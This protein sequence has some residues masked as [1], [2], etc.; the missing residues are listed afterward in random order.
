MVGDAVRSSLGGSRSD[1][2]VA[3]PLSLIGAVGKRWSSRGVFDASTARGP[4]RVGP[5]GLLRILRVGVATR[6]QREAPTEAQTKRSRGLAVAA[7]RGERNAAT[8]PGGEEIGSVIGQTGIDVERPVF[9]GRQVVR[10]GSTRPL[11]LEGAT[12]KSEPRQPPYCVRRPHAA[13]RHLTRRDALAKRTSY[14]GPQQPP[15]TDRSRP[16]GQPID[17]SSA[18]LPSLFPSS[19]IGMRVSS[20]RRT[21]Q[22]REPIVP[23][24]TRVRG[25]GAS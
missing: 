2:Q 23:S 12:S 15:F 3:S 19:S 4:G 11:L 8:E 1:L 7:C 6:G 9:W 13:G 18:R 20:L 24:L 17:A 21:A 10:A 25:P 22:E 5:P 16:V 14:V